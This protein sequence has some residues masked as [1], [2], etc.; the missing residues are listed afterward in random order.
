VTVNF[1]YGLVQV[2]YINLV[3]G[4]LFR[5]TKQDKYALVSQMVPQV[6]E[7]LLE[8]HSS[9]E[10]WIKKK[11]SSFKPLDLKLL[12]PETCPPILRPFVTESN[13]HVVSLPYKMLQVTEQTIYQIIGTFYTNLDRYQ[14]EAR[15]VEKLQRFTDFAQ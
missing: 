2:I 15:Y 9:I 14:F 8:L 4:T 7:T 13:T 5:S 3:L 10:T 6:L 12:H 11:Q 1:Q